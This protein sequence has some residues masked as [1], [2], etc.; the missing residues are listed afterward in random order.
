[1]LKAD[2]AA[3]APAARS[4]LS[5]STVTGC[6]PALVSSRAASA[7]INDVGLNEGFVS[8]WS[9]RVDFFAVEEAHNAGKVRK[10]PS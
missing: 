3:G 4:A 9:M 7:R 6:P 2:L 10:N 5:I 1:M 8:S